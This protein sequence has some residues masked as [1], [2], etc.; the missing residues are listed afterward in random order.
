MAKRRIV[1][2]TSAQVKASL[3][4]GS[5]SKPSLLGGGR[6]AITNGHTQSLSDLD[7]QE[8]W[9]LH[10]TPLPQE[11]TSTPT[12]TS[13]LSVG[14]KSSALKPVS[15]RSSANNLVMQKK[16]RSS[17]GNKISIKDNYHQ[18]EE[19]FSHRYQEYL[20]L[21]SWIEQRLTVFRQLKAQLAASNANQEQT[22]FKLIVEEKRLKEDR[23]YQ[24][25]LEK[26]EETC[27]ALMLIKNRLKEM[28]VT[29]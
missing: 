20:F 26:L 17:N 11:A 9:S 4:T 1:S 24:E 22:I 13:T 15:R 6:L 28:I 23:T 8:T 12:S 18:L 14:V 16:T 29:H 7:S 25:K 3:P 2:N 27:A 5:M 10:D 19:E 21:N